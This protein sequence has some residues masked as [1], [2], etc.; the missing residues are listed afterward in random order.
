M[1]ASFSIK[2]SRMYGILLLVVHFLLIYTLSLTNLALIVRY[3]LSLL[4][5][6]N[7]LYQLHHKVLM[8]NKL[9]WHHLSLNQNQLLVNGPDGLSGELSHRTVVT[10][11]CVV[12]C[13]RFKGQSACQVIFFDAMKTAEFRELRVRLRFS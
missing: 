8:R 1:L 6:L 2:P 7:L 3:S 10:P 5:L 13:V 9:S 12:L 4:V 11:F